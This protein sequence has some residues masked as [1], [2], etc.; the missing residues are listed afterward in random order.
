[1]TGIAIP[2]DEDDF[3]IEDDEETGTGPALVEAPLPPWCLLVV[4]DE[5]GVHAITQLALKSLEFKGRR[6]E[7]LSAYSG[8]EALEVLRGRKDIAVILLDV[9]METDDAGLRCA[10]AIREEL[11]NREVR[12]ILRTGQPGQAPEQRVILDYDINDYKAKTELTAQKLLTTMIAALRTYDHIMTI[13]TSRRGLDM[14]IDASAS[15][16]MARSLE[17]LHSGV[18]IQLQAML[19]VGEDGILCVQRGLPAPADAVPADQDG[20]VVLAASGRYADIVNRPLDARIPE[21]TRR[22]IEACFQSRQSIFA[23]RLTTLYI[24]TPS[25]REVV[26]SFDS[27]KTLSPHDRRMIEVFAAK[28]SLGFE[29][30]YHFNQL[31]A[32]NGAAAAMIAQLVECRV[33]DAGRHALHVA[34]LADAVGRHLAAGGAYAG[35]M[36]GPIMDLLAMASV[37]AAGDAVLKG[38]EAAPRAMIV[39]TGF[40]GDSSRWLDLGAEVTAALREHWDGTGGPAGLKGEEIPLIARII[41]VAEGFDA[42]T[43]DGEDRPAATAADALARIRAEAGRRFDPVVVDALAAVLDDHMAWKSRIGG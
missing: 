33:R 28:V 43:T 12:I 30:L 21:E 18:L 15:L 6:L 27:Q 20:I 1:M 36:D 8:K 37:M 22:Q 41:A 9:V 25:K 31:R 13:E 42:L 29:N 4:D 2:D 11:D 5:P 14:V 34:R 16:F 10:R 40:F 39:A 23:E 24:A 32:A 17:Q 35:R 19:G 38:V 3:L 7:I 26:A